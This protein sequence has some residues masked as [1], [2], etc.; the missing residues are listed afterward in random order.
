M[1]RGD[2]LVKGNSQVLLFASYK[3]A[4]KENDLGTFNNKTRQSLT[5]QNT[6]AVT[7]SEG[8]QM[9]HLI[10]LYFE[11]ECVRNLGNSQILHMTN[12]SQCSC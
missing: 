3:I 2:I 5:G 12:V 11:G 7:Q 6:A 4:L 1:S 8:Q 9:T 10:S